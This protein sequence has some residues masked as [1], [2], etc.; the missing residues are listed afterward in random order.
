MLLATGSGSYDRK[1][2]LEIWHLDTGLCRF[3]TPT[4]S[5]ICCDGLLFSP[6]GSHLVV[7]V[8]DGYLVWDWGNMRCQRIVNREFD[9]LDKWTCDVMDFSPQGH[10]YIMS[11][12]SDDLDVRAWVNVNS[13]T[14]ESNLT[15]CIPV[16]HEKSRRSLH[17]YQRGSS[18]TMQR[19]FSSQFT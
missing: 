2:G 8:L 7:R 17:L 9:V 16:Y 3:I 6:A 12:P 4:S 1:A 11:S 18:G 15:N 19:P 14:S 5:R 10:L 13:L